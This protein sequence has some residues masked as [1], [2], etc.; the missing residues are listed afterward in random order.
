MPDKDPT[1][2]EY[3]AYSEL[4]SAQNALA[5]EIHQINAKLLDLASK[6]SPETL[7]PLFEKLVSHWLEF[8]RNHEAI[9]KLSHDG[10]FAERSYFTRKLR[11]ETF[12][13]FQR[14]YKTLQLCLPEFEPEALQDLSE[15]DIPGEE[16]IEES[17]ELSNQEQ[18]TL[19][20]LMFDKISGLEQKLELIA[21][22]QKS[23]GKG[24]TPDPKPHIPNKPIA[25]TSEAEQV[26]VGA[27]TSSASDLQT[28]YLQTINATMNYPAFPANEHDYR[29]WRNKL[30]AW[31]EAN[32]LI[33]APQK[34]TY[35]MESIKKN[36]AFAAAI[37]SGVDETYNSSYETMLSLLQKEFDKKRSDCFQ[38]FSA[39]IN[40]RPAKK[41]NDRLGEIYRH[42][43]S[44]LSNFESI[45]HEVLPA[46]IV[47]DESLFLA[48]RANAML[49]AVLFQY[50]EEEQQKR[51]IIK[52]NIKP[53]Q[54]PDTTLL[55]EWIREQYINVRSNSHEVKV[56]HKPQQPYQQVMPKTRKITTTAAKGSVK[57][58]LRNIIKKSYVCGCCGAPTR[59]I[60][61]PKYTKMKPSERVEALKVRK[62]CFTCLSDRFDKCRCYASNPTKCKTCQGT[63]HT[64]L[65]VDSTSVRKMET[66]GM[67]SEIIPVSPTIIVEALSA[68]G[69]WK[70]ARALL[71]SGADH[72]L[73]TYA[74]NRRLGG[75]K[76]SKLVRVYDFQ[77]LEVDPVKHETSL[78]LRP[79]NAV[80]LT[81]EEWHFLP[82]VYLRNTLGSVR[83]YTLRNLIPNN[84]IL[85]DASLA[86]EGG[87]IDIIMPTSFWAEIK[88]EGLIRL[89]KTLMLENSLYGYVA[90]GSILTET[91]QHYR[92]ITTRMVRTTPYQYQVNDID[93]FFDYQED[94]P[95]DDEEIVEHIYTMTTRRQEDNRYVVH[96]PLIPN[97]NQ[98]LGESR[99]I[100]IH[101]IRAMWKKLSKQQQ[102]DYLLQW[103]K[104]EQEGYIRERKATEMGRYYIP[105]FG[106][107]KQASLTTALR[108]V[109]DA[110]M[111]T[112]SGI[113]FNNVQLKG[114]KLQTDIYQNMAQFRLG[115]F[116]VMAD[117][118]K[119]YL[120]IAVD[121]KFHQYQHT[122][123]PTPSGHLK[124]M[125]MTTLIFGN[126]ASP[127]LALRTLRELAG[128]IEHLYPMAA[129]ILR[130]FTYI[131]DITTSFISREKAQQAT[132]ELQEALS[133]GKFNLRKWLSND[134]EVLESVPNT[135]KLNC[136]E[137]EMATGGEDTPHA[138][139]GTYWDVT[140]D[141]LRYKVGNFI[142]EKVTTLNLREM[143][144]QI[145]VI[146]DNAGLISPVFLRARRTVQKVYELLLNDQ[147]PVKKGDKRFNLNLP[148]DIVDE[149]NEWVTSLT[150]LRN[151]VIPR[152]SNY[153]PGDHISICAFADGSSYA[154]G[155]AIYLRVE[156]E[157]A[158]YMTLLLGKSRLKPSKKGF[159]VPKL[160]LM[161]L[162]LATKFLRQIYKA[163]EAT[164]KLNGIEVPI[165]VYVFS[166][167][168]IVLAW[169]Q[170]PTII[171]TVFVENHL[172][173]IRKEVDI[174]DFYH[175]PSEDNAADVS[176][177]GCTAE[178]LPAAWFEGPAYLL[179]PG[180][181]ETLPRKQFQTFEEKRASDINV[182]KVT[183]D[184]LE[185]V[186]L[187]H[188]DKIS[189]WPATIKRMETLNLAK[190]LFKKKKNLSNE[191]KYRAFIAIITQYQQ[192]AFYEEIQMLTQ[193]RKVTGRCSKLNLFIDDEGMIRCRTRIQADYLAYDTKN[194][195]LLPPA[196]MKDNDDTAYITNKLI[197]HYHKEAL[198]GGTEK[199]MALMTQQFHILNGKRG[200]KFIVQRCVKCRRFA[201]T[202]RQLMGQIPAINYTPS[203]PFYHISVDQAGPIY[204]K[205][206]TRRKLRSDT[207][208]LGQK[209]WIVLFVC[210]TT[211]AIH[212][213]M[214]DTMA[215][216]DLFDAFQNFFSIRGM[217]RSV[218]M[219]NFASNKKVAS[220]IQKVTT[221]QLKTEITRAAKAKNSNKATANAINKFVT[222]CD[223]TDVLAETI[224][225]IERK[226][227]LQKTVFCRGKGDLV[228]FD[229]SPE[230]APNHNG[231]VE[232]E[233]KVV[234]K[235]L[236][237]MLCGSVITKKEMYNMLKRIEAVINSKP[238]FAMEENGHQIYVTPAHFWGGRSVLGV[239]H[240]ERTSFA[241]NKRVHHQDGQFEY[242]WK[243]YKNFMF[244]DLRTRPKWNEKKDN[245]AVGQLVV[246]RDKG[247][248]IMAWITGIIIGT[249]PGP[250]GLVR[251]VHLRMPNGH[252][253]HRSTAD[254]IPLPVFSNEEINGEKQ[255]EH[256]EFVPLPSQGK[257][258][259]S[260]LD[261][262]SQADQGESDEDMP[263]DKNT[264]TPS[265]SHNLNT[266]QILNPIIQDDQEEA[267]SDKKAEGFATTKTDTDGPGTAHAPHSVEVNSQETSRVPSNA[268]ATPQTVPTVP[269]FQ[270]LDFLGSVRPVVRRS[271]RI[272]AKIMY[273]L[274][275]I[276]LFFPCIL[277]QPGNLPGGAIVATRRKAFIT[278]GSA[279]IHLQTDIYPKRDEGFLR[280]ALDQIAEQC[281]R[282]TPL[283][284]AACTRYLELMED[285]LQDLKAVS[286]KHRGEDS[287]VELKRSK[288]GTRE[289]ILI[290]LWRFLFSTVEERDHPLSIPISTTI[291]MQKHVLNLEEQ[292]N[293][294]IE[295]VT[296]ISNMFEQED[297]RW[298]A[299]TKVIALFD[300]A[301]TQFLHQV[302][303]MKKLYEREGI[304]D[305]E[306]Q[307]ATDQIH[308]LSKHTMPPV[309]F[310]DLQKI[311][312][313][314]TT[315][316]AGRLV[317]I[318]SVPL[319]L[320]DTFE[321]IT[322]V[323]TPINDTIADF[324]P[325]TIVA[326]PSHYASNYN[327]VWTNGTIAIVEVDMLINIGDGLASCAA[328]FATHQNTESCTRRRL[329]KSYD[330][331][332]KVGQ[333]TYAFVS[334]QKK[335]LL[336]VDTHH[337]EIIVNQSG[338][339]HIPN[340][341][342]I[343]TAKFTIHAQTMEISTPTQIFHVPVTEIQQMN[344]T[345]ETPKKPINASTID[346]TEM[347]DL[348]NNTRTW[349]DAIVPQQSNW[350]I[351]AALIIIVVGTIVIISQ[352][353]LK[354]TLLSRRDSPET[355]ELVEQRTRQIAN[356]FSRPNTP[357]R[358]NRQV[359]R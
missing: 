278:A 359:S 200:I 293:V 70:K 257:E 159:T 128:E 290:T 258:K 32:N 336:C 99:M 220:E 135:D 339:I 214:L 37:V 213:E 317:H 264:F 132:K 31:D 134:D 343:E 274:A 145:A 34:A 18:S 195:I 116:A 284:V 75:K 210:R 239:P 177:R 63:H 117:I 230:Y 67:S 282:N 304:T 12:K 56:N 203:P 162:R 157:G 217:P 91:T 219:D 323:A 340:N 178:T 11:D 322:I 276:C 106:V 161:G 25:S 228:K 302:K 222:S 43:T 232:A 8:K 235:Y 16:E 273:A 126:K 202:S 68:D 269:I 288:R 198:H 90:L 171:R 96:I 103:D 329:A 21:S 166:D 141:T 10:R 341:C 245:L 39:I 144:R 137:K 334:N 138:V 168:T 316:E 4:N 277:G 294:E 183:V 352:P 187:Q 318:I 326:S 55:L 146:Y 256:N 224:A 303:K 194:P 242:F 2:P 265:S 20:K 283:A 88:T 78:T 307:R 227:P 248:P 266:P 240:P 26:N 98:S 233:V 108:I 115:E 114:K 261:Q 312:T 335:E 193:N 184:T 285:A 24:G 207:G 254:V 72:P 95:K 50:L 123:R 47:V 287:F 324:P 298:H 353:N 150:A 310:K 87:V 151:L 180:V 121:E 286:Q 299:E 211:R 349:M 136:M 237:I 253:S 44:H 148:D 351:Y 48:H 196:K 164:L 260:T 192:Q 236:K 94:P 83:T 109:F 215:A 301:R 308:R 143:L 306:F 234:K 81:N 118:A 130:Q 29:K 244:R 73:A 226:Y 22:S 77:G 163:V 186:V 45:L 185:Q 188:L 13:A 249:E 140:N 27:S 142:F 271:P 54:I 347:K 1:S 125:V 321:E 205:R 120:Q 139:L 89:S 199:T 218:L 246:V 3:V 5:L 250:D 209:L 112:T 40:F 345:E 74:L 127:F 296:N 247:T 60:E 314:E 133:C 268:N 275:M 58:E 338:I 124:E 182:K 263:I 332:T 113:S 167:S 327:V 156:R 41:G 295:R 158:V 80:H 243:H 147:P 175:V 149:W 35:L 333:N 17:D 348:I 107:T 305:D 313:T 223:E 289:G 66:R 110:A 59:T 97:A 165:A 51:F 272:A 100:C 358:G 309:D 176:S 179:V 281:R 331:W 154:Y 69:T 297:I 173:D 189:E 259:A 153:R 342:R 346:T 155:C 33:P 46:D 64:T 14:G 15:E 119:M 330:E 291:T 6:G 255:D 38:H 42:F 76:A 85:A 79:L 9:V 229:F 129:Q 86:E 102:A 262:I 319:V 270:P 57:N 93:K 350:W 174:K 152:W 315:T 190:E 201:T 238:L 191:T 280:G 36:N 252:T 172:K 169:V 84:I 221:Q 355:I 325:Q 105:H 344:F 23:S 122:F 30:A 28:R 300:L 292:L 231:I 279:E 212:I 170:N 356:P 62:T 111:K 92:P 19:F 225:Q 101:R 206:T 49:A 204:I 357:E 251:V 61:C 337:R 71:D 7:E 82:S 65:H 320:D 160:E 53:N 181:L 104:L 328:A 208:D 131:D 267:R 354:W 311:A 197:N 52:H 216:K 241:L